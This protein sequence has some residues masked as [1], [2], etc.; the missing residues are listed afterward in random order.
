[1]R[2]CLALASAATGDEFVCFRVVAEYPGVAEDAFNVTFSSRHALTVR[3]CAAFSL[4]LG[5][6][7]LIGWALGIPQ[8]VQVRPDWTPMVVN[9]AIGFVLAGVGLLA[10]TMHSRASAQ[11]AMLVGVLLAL[12]ALQEWWVLFFDLSPAFSLPDLHRPLQLDSPHPGRMAP[13]T[14]LCFLLFGSGLA[15]LAG[16]AASAVGAWVQRAGIAVLGVGALGVV[17][18]SL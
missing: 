10:A 13:N 17:G 11:V 18:Y 2:G 6:M 16:L 7:T 15:A 5:C 14:A 4:G 9:T 1:M 8:L 12:L 3:L